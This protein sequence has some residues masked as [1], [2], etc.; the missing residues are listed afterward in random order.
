M[1]WKRLGNKAT[2]RSSQLTMRERSSEPRSPRLR[3][4]LR[5]ACLVFAIIIAA[6]V[7]AGVVFRVLIWVELDRIKREGDPV[8]L[9]QLAV[10]PPDSRNGAFAYEK[11][12]AMMQNGKGRF[13]ALRDLNYE[14]ER[15]R[16]P[17]LW[18]QARA[19]L[20]RL[21]PIVAIADRAA[22]MPTCK[23]G[24]D[25]EKGYF[26]R[27]SD[28]C[29]LVRLLGGYARLLAHS[30][31]TDEAIRVLGLSVRVA[32]ALKPD[33]VAI[34]Y[35]VR[36]RM[37]RESS[38]IACEIVAGSTVSEDDAKA[39]A[40]ALGRSGLG[41]QAL[42]VPKW[43]RVIGCHDFDRAARQG[44]PKDWFFGAGLAVSQFECSWI[45][46]PI[47]WAD[48]LFYLRAMR[49]AIRDADI[50]F[51]K[52]PK[53]PPLTVPC[54]CQVRACVWPFSNARAIDFDAYK[55]RR[56]ADTFQAKINGTRL[57][58]ALRVYKQRFGEYPSRLSDLRKLGWKLDM[59]D[60]FTG[61]EFVH[62]QTAE[63][64]LLYSVG[65]NLK[66]ECARQA[67]ETDPGDGDIV[68]KM[69]G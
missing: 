25:W 5:K 39:L 36:G 2:A 38:D 3:R 22:S 40:D 53:P 42:I 29:D 68:W 19:E 69:R 37:Y 57:A 20:P 4:R 14:S 63:G 7:L 65:A 66:D 18:D 28:V 21:A 45:G 27:N 1:L 55:Q 52:L 60:P 62:R 23:F 43:E 61:R 44:P 56:T 46:R 31:R 59:T 48:E 34:C 50:P 26:P 6:Y 12:F 32:D 35:L 49:R 51:R 67:S 58:L 64:C 9:A 15:A 54:E 11:A 17:R 24:A 13:S 41:H 10:M 33:C 16:N 8:S 47:L 30:G